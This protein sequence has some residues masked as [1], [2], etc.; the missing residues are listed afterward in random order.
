MDQ[1]TDRKEQTACAAAIRT[2]RD[3]LAVMPM[4]DDRITHEPALCRDYW[5]LS[6]TQNRLPSGSARTTKSA[7]S[8]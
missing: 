2:C 3:Q 7:S 1:G 4:W 5:L 8:G 6:I